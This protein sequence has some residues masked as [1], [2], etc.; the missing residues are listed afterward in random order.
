MTSMARSMAEPGAP[1]QSLNVMGRPVARGAGQ[2]N[3]AR[4]R[5]RP[6]RQQN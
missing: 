1:T 4:D 2:R 5:G 6:S 3:A